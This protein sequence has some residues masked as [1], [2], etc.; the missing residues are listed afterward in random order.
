MTMLS[1]FLEPQRARVVV[2]SLTHDGHRRVLKRHDGTPLTATK[3]IALPDICALLAVSGRLA[4]LPELHSRIMSVWPRD[5]DD[6]VQHM[7]AILEHVSRTISTVR[8][9]PYRGDVVHLVGWSNQAGRMVLATWST[10]DGFLSVGA[11]RID[12]GPLT[13]TL[14]PAIEPVPPFPQTDAEILSFA[15][16]Q[17]DHAEEKYFG[18]PLFVAEVTRDKIDIRRVGDLGVPVGPSAEVAQVAHATVV[19]RMN[20]AWTATTDPGILDGSGGIEVRYGLATQ[21]EKLWTSVLCPGNATQAYLPGVQF[22]KI[23]MVK[24]RG[25]NNLATGKWST[26]VLHKVGGVSIAVDTAGLVPNAATVAQSA[27][28]ASGTVTV[29]TNSFVEADATTLTWLN[30]T[31]GAVLVQIEHS[32]NLTSVTKTGTANGFGYMKSYWSVSGGGGSSGVVFGPLTAVGAAEA[33]YNTVDQVS[34]SAG[35]T[36]TVRCAVGA[37]EFI[38]TGNVVTNY[39]NVFTRVTAIK[40]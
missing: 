33:N 31:A 11:E 9:T 2:D 1:V 3:M 32:G 37:Q 26:A 20:A 35:L 21:D 8:D 23:Y 17:I 39:S 12:D 36:I 25:F 24:V 4:L 13:A 16:E 30:N 6:L 38:G 27:T 18:G 22:D 29:T 40:R 7:P 19:Q 10:S 28:A 34:V 14:Q 15:R 5:F